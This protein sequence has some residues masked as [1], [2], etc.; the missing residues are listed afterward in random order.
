M[1]MLK[2]IVLS[3]SR[4]SVLPSLSTPFDDIE[5]SDRPRPEPRTIEAS[6]NG[7]EEMS[8]SFPTLRDWRPVCSPW[9]FPASCFAHLNRGGH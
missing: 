2:P 1:K 8:E 3:R 4:E 6:F 7:I 5:E 9:T